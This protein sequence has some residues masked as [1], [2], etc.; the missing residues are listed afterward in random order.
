MPR[1]FFIIVIALSSLGC[2]QPACAAVEN[3]SRLVRESKPRAPEDERRAF[4]LPAGFEIQLFA[5]DVQLGGKPINMAFDTRGR[6]WVTCTQEYPYAVKKEKWSADSTRAIGSKDT[7]RI[8][9]DTDGDGRADR[10]T[11]FADDLN[12]PTGIQPYKNGCVAWSIPNILFFEDTRAAGNDKSQSTNHNEAP[13]PTKADKRTILFGP[14]GFEKD[15][16]GMISSMRLG[17]DG[18]IY[19]THGFSN[20]S[21]FRVLPQ[22]R[23]KNQEPG[24]RN[25]ETLDVTSGSVF[26]FRP[27]G[28]AVE[29][30]TSGQ[31]NPF[32]LCWD[33]WGNLYSADCHSN[34]ITQLIRGAEYPHFGIKPG[35]LGFGPVMCDHAHGSTGIAGIVYIDGG[36][37]GPE[38]DD[39][40]F[41]GNPVTSKVNHDFITFTGSTPKAN[42]EPDFITCDD[43]WFRPVDLQ[44]GPDGALYIADFYNK[45]IGHYEVPL[46][47]P[48]RDRKSGR[49]WRVVRTDS[50]GHLSDANLAGIADSE[51]ADTFVKST[52]LSLRYL[53]YAEMRMRGLSDTLLIGSLSKAPVKMGN[54]KRDMEAM[55][56]RLM[57]QEIPDKPGIE[58]VPVLLRWLHETPRQD[59][60]LHYALEVALSKLLQLP[61][62]YPA[63]RKE[64]VVPELF[65]ELARISLAIP[66]P[67]SA[68]WLLDQVKSSAAATKGVD[69]PGASRVDAGTRPVPFP[70]LD[71]IQLAQVFTH[72]AR[73][74]PAEREAELIDLVQRQFPEDLETQLDL[75]AAVRAGRD[76]HSSFVVRRSSFDTWSSI[77]AQRLLAEL[78]QSTKPDWQPVSSAN[79]QSS[80]PWFRATRPC[81]DKKERAFL[82]SHPPGGESLTGILRSKTF[83]LPPTLSFWLAGHRGFPTQPPHDKNFVRLVDADSGREIARAFP[84]R[85]DKARLITWETGQMPTKRAYFELVD[86]DDGS[87]YAWLA[88]GGFEPRVVEITDP[89]TTL[90]DRYVRAAAELAAMSVGASEA[91]H[92]KERRPAFPKLVN[93]VYAVPKKEGYSPET[94]AA[95]AAASRWTSWVW[96][97]EV[98]D[99]SRDPELASVALAI[100]YSGPPEKSAELAA[101]FHSLPTRAQNKLA[102]A[103]ATSP[104]TARALLDHAA[105]ATL[106]EPLVSAKLK[107]LHDAEISARLDKLT[108]TLPPASK[109]VNKL[110]VARLKTFNPIKA[111][112]ERGKIVFAQTCVACHRIGILGNIVGPQLD[113]IGMRGAERLLEDILDP[114]RAVDPAFRLHI[115]KKKNGEL[116]T[117]LLRR[118]A[119]ET[120]I[121]VDAA[122]QEHGIAKADMA[123]DQVSAFS[124]MPSGLGEAL[125]KQQ[126]DDLLKFLLER[127]S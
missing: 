78:S 89:G 49:I 5:D 62:A 94:R 81:T 86:G 27:D 35:P 72:I 90:R 98:M 22:N 100:V 122:G 95:L 91:P 76:S 109:A 92:A 33:S 124:L 56:R 113:G 117:G 18:W 79:P 42:E 114:N 121:F 50:A 60:Q 6:L 108:A 25:Q 107:S 97:P 70:G 32:G 30:W 55:A 61:G 12:I 44:L 8:L 7:I 67:D 106:A 10:V 57:A 84:P 43:D 69:L 9:D 40:M 16:H 51:V 2:L 63:L 11:V 82:D 59:I 53:A 102:S 39:H 19:A 48:G 66:T 29:I 36:V 38:W 105:P 101:A 85:N 13:V 23:T 68:I 88:A 111:D 118:E 46:D 1:S 34:P 103:L 58:R 37:W 4:H 65:G 126:L 104:E 77:L 119:D 24:T 17:L 123:D 116:F 112:A 99:L 15:T 41:V 87:A 125:S 73:H 54:G 28:A 20:T 3:V 93:A 75:F 127:K 71:R 52:N 14:L 47:H 45:I 31:V 64:L 21:H 80:S 110:I 83:D 74:L 120:L 115:V 26:R 96:P